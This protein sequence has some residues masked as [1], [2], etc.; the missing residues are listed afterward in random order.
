[1]SL[2]PCYNVFCFGCDVTATKGNKSLHNFGIDTNGLLFWSVREGKKMVKMKAMVFFPPSPPS[3]HPFRQARYSKAYH[4]RQRE[5]CEGGKCI[6][7]YFLFF[8]YML[9][10]VA[11]ETIVKYS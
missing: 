4:R 8:L 6:K 1:M 2:S 10:Y 7:F 5:V 9:L 11:M 3:C